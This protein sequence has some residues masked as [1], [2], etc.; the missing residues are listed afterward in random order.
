MYITQS[1]GHYTM[2]YREDFSFLRISMNQA[3][4]EEK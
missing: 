3:S 1:W 4:S 2:Y